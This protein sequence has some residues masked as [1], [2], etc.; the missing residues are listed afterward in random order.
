MAEARVAPAA[1][2]SRPDAEEGRAGGAPVI[3]FVGPSLPPEGAPAGVAVWPPARR[4]DVLRA[5]AAGARTLV[6]VD[7]YF[8]DAPATS[9][10]ELRY[11]LDAGARVI[12]AASM[13][14][15]RAAE[16]APFGMEPLGE[17]AGWYACG[18]LHA[19]DEV[20]LLHGPSDMGYRGVTVPLVEVRHALRWQP[21]AEIAPAAAEL[22]AALAALPF[23]RRDAATVAT[24][25]RRWLGD[26]AAA[27]LM[28]RLRGP[29]V[30]QADARLALLAAAQVTA[31]ASGRAGAPGPGRL[32]SAADAAGP[33]GGA[34]GAAGPP[35]LACSPGLADPAGTA[36]RR[37]RLP[38]PSAAADAGYLCAYLERYL[39][40]PAA[41]GGAPLG[42]AWGL[43]RL[44]HPAAP[45]WNAELHDRFGLA[46]AAARARLEPDAAATAA[47]A[48]ALVRE[49]EVRWHRTLLPRAEYLAEARLRGLAACATAAGLRGGDLGSAAPPWWACR[50]FSFAPPFAAAVALAAA[51]A[52]VC[53]CHRAQG[54]QPIAGAERSRLAA[55]LWGCS[56]AE[57]RVAARARGLAVAS[58]SY[59]LAAA[60]DLALVAERLPHA[61]NEYPLARR[62]LLATTWAVGAPLVPPAEH[63]RPV[64]A[65]PPGLAQLAFLVGGVWVADDPGKPGEVV[66]EAC[67]WGLAGRFIFT[68]VTHRR[69]AAA[70]ATARGAF[71]WDDDDGLLRSWSFGSGGAWQSAVQ[72]SGTHGP[73]SWTFLS[74]P[75][76]GAAGSSRVTL[77]HS[78]PDVLEVESEASG[79]AMSTRRYERR[80]G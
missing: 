45:A 4:G 20:A 14:A 80:G 67:R 72:A 1:T 54:G 37:A 64:S 11:A 71:A 28:A 25:A 7:G 26:A 35:A 34:A 6:L 42:A 33:G 52:E 63:Q 16:L 38:A 66:E 51:A 57:L 12:G 61:V 36:G 73:L 19:D 17:V 21:A 78:A 47:L 56:A 53:E 68:E 31:P 8:H 69:G 48:R 32:V 50:A 43:A 2:G 13:G 15:L 30:K 5:L 46:A 58:P 24:L 60:V 70:V 44:L 9:H 74:T 55:E 23:T 29:G 18:A 49:H 79:G 39:E 75:D 10:Q 40:A 27:E 65:H 77:T 41:N 3:A 62:E 76:G 59:G 22:L